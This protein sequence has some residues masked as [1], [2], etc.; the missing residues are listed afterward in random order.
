MPSA[1][2]VTT[3]FFWRFFERCGAQFVSFFVSIILAR[4]LE[5]AVYGEIA[6]IT[7]FIA[8]LRVF[9]DSGFGSALIQK[10]N[11]DDLDFSSVFYF[12]I[13][14]CLIMYG[15][16]FVIAPFIANF[17]HLPHLTPVIRVL[18]LTLVVSGVRNIQQSYVSKNLIFK[19]FFF[20]TLGATFVSAVI[21]IIMAYS[22]YGV[23]ALVGQSL[24]N[25]TLG[26]VILWNT[27]KWRPKLM[28]SLQRLKGLFNF[29]WKLL[30][31]SILEVLYSKLCQLII[32]RIYTAKDLAFYNQG[33]HFPSVIISN[34]NSSINSVLL[35]A[36]SAEQDDR[37]RVRS[38]TRRAISI[39]TYI[40]MPMMMGLAVC[41]EPLVRLILTEKWLPCVPFLRIFCF[42][43]AFWPVH[44]ANLN[45]IKALGRSDL[46]LKLEI[47]KKIVGLTAILATMNISVMAM[48]YT[49]FV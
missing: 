5:P 34:I 45:A 48:A 3:N 8:I 1:K 24:T 23:W 13:V 10:K 35:P 17:Y 22:G 29:G 30:A 36:M 32:G 15:T 21:G 19:K 27:V 28:F 4:L 33:A 26:T 40:M 9:V 25:V 49:I 43:F 2:T 20:A 18:S 31:S 7:V 11:A 46:F 41:A 44:T 6:L 37:N 12:N 16:L 42:S 38:M 14:V 39:S 47:A